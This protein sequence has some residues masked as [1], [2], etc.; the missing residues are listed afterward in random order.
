MYKVRVL[1]EINDRLDAEYYNPAAL[2]T[3][4]KME[5]KGTVTTFGDLVDEGYRVVYHGTDSINGLKDSEVLPFLSPTQIDA[6]GSINFEDADKL[7]LYYK[8]QYPKG[9]GK[10]GE[11]L[12]EVKG[13][14]SKVGIVP[15]AFPKNLMIS[16]SLYKATLNPRRVDSHYVLAFLK[17]KHGQILK[18]RL[19]SNTI[20]NYIA[21]DALYS[22]PVIEL[23]EKAQKYIGDKV[24]QAEQLRAWAKSIQLKVSELLPSYI[25]EI[26]RYKAKCYRAKDIIPERLDSLFYHPDYSGLESKMKA[27]GCKRLGLITKQVKDAWNKK[28]AEAFEY[29]E[30]GGL[31][32]TTGQVLSATTPTAGAPS[33]AKT[34]VQQGDVLV[35]TVRPNRKN[36]GF[37]VDNVAHSEMVATSGFSVLRFSSL[38]QAAFYHAWL[39]TDD[40]T[41]QLMRWNSGSAYPAIDDDVPLNIIIPDFEKTFV[42]NWGQKLLDAHFAYVYAKMLTEAAKTLVEALIEGQ[43]TEQQLIQ[44][45]QAL[46]DG[47]NSLDQAILSKLSA[48]GYAIE[49][50]TPLFSDV[51]ELYSLLEEAAQAEAEE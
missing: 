37:I 14:V 30:I 38:T 24:R 32:I 20:I 9:L 40:A 42:D 33:R 12:V 27:K 25:N 45:Q 47:E 6:N 44:A 18:N 26:Q 50:A 28:K 22:I 15:S 2:S 21:K 35:S 16:G 29:Y 46:E 4:K 10:A 34:K 39:R 17:S 7:P 41:A 11:I 49:G 43:L 19:T 48:E 8:D 36:I 23:K 51:D 1:Q 31:D 3:L 5:T 13:N